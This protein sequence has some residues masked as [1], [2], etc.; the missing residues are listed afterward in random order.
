MA[1]NNNGGGIQTAPAQRLSDFVKGRVSNSLPDSSYLPGLISS[2]LHFWLPE[3]IGK[4][5]RE[6]F[7][8][9]DKKMHGFITDQAIVVG[10]ESRSSSP[11]RIPRN[12]E[13]FE[14]INIQGLYPAGEGSGYSGGITSSAIDGENCANKIAEK[15]NL[16]INSK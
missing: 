6:G 10:V 14:H 5:L 9:F 11:I 2:P 16:K 3:I 7:K 4:N 15:L 1:Y 12:K 8:A 13:T